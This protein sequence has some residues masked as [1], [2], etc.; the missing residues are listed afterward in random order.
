MSGQE[1]IQGVDKMKLSYKDNPAEILDKLLEHHDIKTLKRI[2]HSKVRKKEPRANNYFTIAVDVYIIRHD[3]ESKLEWAI[4]QIAEK[5]NISDKTI[6]NHLTKFRKEMKEEIEKIPAYYSYSP[7]DFNN[8][9]DGYIAKVYQWFNDGC[10]Y[11]E[12]DKKYTEYTNVFKS[13]LQDIHK[14]NPR[15]FDITEIPF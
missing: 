8:F 2:L 9:I 14:K 11:R 3:K 12:P 10:D 6:K 15:E 5:R 4:D 13:Y 7:Q 1:L